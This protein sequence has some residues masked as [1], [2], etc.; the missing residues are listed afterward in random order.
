LTRIAHHRP[1]GTKRAAQGPP[2]L[3]G[4][5]ASGEILREK[6]RRCRSLSSIY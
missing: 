2:A 6:P 5:G 4:R 1:P 3:L